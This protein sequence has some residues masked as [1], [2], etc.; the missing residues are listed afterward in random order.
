MYKSLLVF[1]V[2]TLSSYNVMAK[3]T[4]IG[5]GGGGGQIC[6]TVVSGTLECEDSLG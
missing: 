6:C 5:E 3:C 2:L 4:S 1:S